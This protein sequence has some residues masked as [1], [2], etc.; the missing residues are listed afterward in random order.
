MLILNFRVLGKRFS[1]PEFFMNKTPSRK[2]HC[3]AAHLLSGRV[4][5]WH[6]KAGF[7]AQHHGNR[8]Q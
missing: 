8:A 2:E 4:L 5:A 6:A 3:G 1:E 7:H